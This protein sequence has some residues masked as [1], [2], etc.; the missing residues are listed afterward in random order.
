MDEDRIETEV[1][2][3]IKE[4]CREMDE[5]RNH[6]PKE[7]SEIPESQQLETFA[8]LIKFEQHKLAKSFKDPLELKLINDQIAKEAIQ[9]ITEVS[10]HSKFKGKFNVITVKSDDDVTPDTILF[11]N[12]TTRKRHIN[13]EGTLYKQFQESINKRIDISSNRDNE[14]QWVRITKK[15]SAIAVGIM[16][17]ILYKFRDAGNMLGYKKHIASR[18]SPDKPTGFEESTSIYQQQGDLMAISEKDLGAVTSSISSHLGNSE[19]NGFISLLSGAGDIW[20]IINQDNDDYLNPDIALLKKFGKEK[21][22]D[23]F[24]GFI[25]GLIKASFAIFLGHT[26]IAVFSAASMM[27]SLVAFG[28][29][30]MGL[31]ALYI[32]AKVVKKFMH[33]IGL[34]NDG[35]SILIRNASNFALFTRFNNLLR[36]LASMLVNKEQGS[37]MLLSDVYVDDFWSSVTESSDV[38]EIL[39]NTITSGNNTEIEKLYKLIGSM[40]DNYLISKLKTPEDVVKN[41]ENKNILSSSYETNIVYGYERDLVREYKTQF[42]ENIFQS[43][44]IKKQLNEEVMT[45]DILDILQTAYV[46]YQTYY[47]GHYPDQRE[48]VEPSMRF[49]FNEKFDTYD[50]DRN[51]GA[52][53]NL[54]NKLYEARKGKRNG[55]K[56]KPIASE[57]TRNEINNKYLVQ[58]DDEGRYV[59][60]T[61][62]DFMKEYILELKKDLATMEFTAFRHRY[63]TQDKKGFDTLKALIKNH[64]TLLDIKIPEVLEEKRNYSGFIGILL[65]QIIDNYIEIDALNMIN[66]NLLNETVKNSDDVTAEH[67]DNTSSILLSKMF[68][69]N[70]KILEALLIPTALEFPIKKY[71][72]KDINSKTFHAQSTVTSFLKNK[73]LKLAIK[74]TIY[75]TSY[76]LKLAFLEMMTKFQITPA[77]NIL[78]FSTSGGNTF[79]LA[80]KT[81]LE[82]HRGSDILGYSRIGDVRDINK[83]PGSLL[84]LTKE[85]AYL[86]SSSLITFFEN[87]KKF[88]FKTGLY[89]PLKY[90]KI[91]EANNC[92]DF[93]KVLYD[94]F[95]NETNAEYTFKNGS[96]YPH[97]VL[98]AHSIYAG[99]KLNKVDNETEVNLDMILTKQF[100]SLIGRALGVLKKDPI[101]ED[102]KVSFDIDEILEVSKDDVNHKKY[103]NYKYNDST[104]TY[105]AVCFE[106]DDKKYIIKKDYLDLVKLADWQ[107]AGEDGAEFREGIRMVNQEVLDNLG[108]EDIDE[109]ND[110]CLSHGSRY[111][112]I[113]ED[114][115]Q[116]KIRYQDYIP[117]EKTNIRVILNMEALT[118]IYSMES[119][120]DKKSVKLN[121][122]TSYEKG[123]F[124]GIYN[125]S[126][127]KA[128]IDLFINGLYHKR[129]YNI[130]SNNLLDI[131][132][133][134]N[135]CFHEVTIGFN[136]E[137]KK[138]MKIFKVNEFNSLHNWV[139]TNF[140]EISK[141]YNEKILSDEDRRVSVETCYDETYLCKAHKWTEG[142]NDPKLKWDKDYLDGILSIIISSYGSF[143]GALK[144][145]SQYGAFLYYLHHLPYNNGL[146]YLYP[147][148]K[149][150]L[151]DSY[152][153]S[154]Y[155]TKLSNELNQSGIENNLDKIDNLMSLKI[156]KKMNKTSSKYSFT[157]SDDFKFNYL[158]AFTHLVYNNNL[159]ADKVIVVKNTGNKVHSLNNIGF[160]LSCHDINSLAIYSDNETLI[161]NK[162][163]NI[164]GI[165]GNG[166]SLVAKNLLP[167]LN[168]ALPHLPLG[169][170]L[171]DQKYWFYYDPLRNKNILQCEGTV[172]EIEDSVANL[173]SNTLEKRM[174]FQDITDF[175]YKFSKIDN[176][177]NAVDK[178]NVVAVN[179]DAAIEE[180]LQISSHKLKAKIIA[181]LYCLS[182]IVK[183]RNLSKLPV[184][185]KDNM[186]K[187]LNSETW[188]FTSL[189]KYKVHFSDEDHTDRFKFKINNDFANQLLYL[190]LETFSRLMKIYITNKH[191]QLYGSGTKWEQLNE[192]QLFD[193]IKPEDIQMIRN[194]PLL[195]DANI[196]NNLLYSTTV[197]ISNNNN[198]LEADIY[199][200]PQRN[201]GA[202][203]TATISGLVNNLSAKAANASQESLLTSTDRV[204]SNFYSSIM[205]ELIQTEVIH[206]KVVGGQIKEQNKFSLDNK[207]KAAYELIF[208]KIDPNFISSFS[209]IQNRFYNNII[210]KTSNISVRNYIT[211]TVITGS[212]NDT[213]DHITT[214]VSS[215]ADRKLFFD[216]ILVSGD[217]DIYL[218]YIYNILR[219]NFQIGFN[220][221]DKTL[222]VVVDNKEH[223]SIIK[224]LL[225]VRLG[226]DTSDQTF[227]TTQKIK[228]LKSCT[229]QMNES[230]FCH[231]GC[232]HTNANAS[233]MFYNTLILG[234]FLST[235]VTLDPIASAYYDIDDYEDIS[236]F[237]QQGNHSVFYNRYNEFIQNNYSS[238]FGNNDKPGLFC[239]GHSMGG[240]YSSTFGYM[241]LF[242]AVK[243]R[244]DPQLIKELSQISAETKVHSFAPPRAFNLTTSVISEF[245]Y[246]DLFDLLRDDV[247]HG[248][249]VVNI[250]NKGDPIQK[251]PF[252]F[253][254]IGSVVLHDETIVNKPGKLLWDTEKA[255]Y[256]NKNLY[257]KEIEQ[258]IKKIKLTIDVSNTALIKAADDL[259][260]SV[261]DM[262]YYKLTKNIAEVSNNNFMTYVFKNPE[263]PGNS[264]GFEKRDSDFNCVKNHFNNLYVLCVEQKL[265]N[266]GLLTNNIARE[267]EEYNTT[268]EKLVKGIFENK[269]RPI[270]YVVENI[271]E[272]INLLDLSQTQ[273]GL[274][275]TLK[276]AVLNEKFI[277]E[278]QTTRDEI[279]NN[280]RTNY[281]INYNY[282]NF[283]SLAN[284]LSLYCHSGIIELVNL[285][286]TKNLSLH[287]DF[288]DLPANEYILYS[289]ENVDMNPGLLSSALYSRYAQDKFRE[290]PM[291]VASNYL[292]VI[293]SDIDIATENV[294][295]SSSNIKSREASNGKTLYYNDTSG[296]AVSNQ[297]LFSN[298]LIND[299]KN[300][301]TSNYSLETLFCNRCI[302]RNIV[303]KPKK[304]LLKG[305]VEKLSFS[306]LFCLETNKYYGYDQSW[307]GPTQHSTQKY[308]MYAYMANNYNDIL[309]TC[310]MTIKELAKN[311]KCNEGSVERI[312]E[313]RFDYTIESFK[314]PEKKI[315]LRATLSDIIKKVKHL[316]D[317]NRIELNGYL[318]DEL[319]SGYFSPNSGNNSPENMNNSVYKVKADLDE[320]DFGDVGERILKLGIKGPAYW[321]NIRLS[322]PGWGDFNKND[323]ISIT[324][325][326]SNYE[327]SPALKAAITYIING[328]NYYNNFNTEQGSNEDFKPIMKEQLF[329]L[330][331]LF[332]LDND[333]DCDA[334]EEAEAKKKAAEREMV[335]EIARTIDDSEADFATLLIGDGT[336]HN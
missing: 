19:Q 71:K 208:G 45:N 304:I 40:R 67:I 33:M 89:E 287:D 66:A 6:L 236:S 217:S 261:A 241:T 219:S 148:E 224:K 130:H 278:F 206:L 285:I 137:D 238:H 204:S 223:K 315:S 37:I 21:F 154:L 3:V 317:M 155:L 98:I 26:I 140:P 310:Q 252:I 295:L 10:N 131:L 336:S 16:S 209:K 123:I 266:L 101:N 182:L 200:K 11:Y 165:Y 251:V 28:A 169:L 324:V 39:Q 246:T 52:T 334:Y 273:I 283:D 103:K 335:L 288:W 9:I 242:Q 211:K 210:Q 332:I 301:L 227:T 189:E 23:G 43:V 120:L 83:E 77:K 53:K 205:D 180:P 73:V 36:W 311:V 104:G 58:A 177:I 13:K 307:A 151:Y 292:E 319:Q 270:E 99:D 156:F 119:E 1:N 79:G 222:E 27:A 51:Y 100:K 2:S 118:K 143:R 269:H 126:N 56:T 192:N 327:E 54:L 296:S 297:A 44:K 302:V 132:Y 271:V 282:E 201:M 212:E 74:S 157:I 188:R 272:L 322:R 303:C 294:S 196:V 183:L 262:R 279:L 122:L 128:E 109:L 277:S 12:S 22:V 184:K 32:L 281:Q 325:T 161:N 166:V 153:F 20:R 90:K 274:S 187:N 69:T 250:S 30:I 95:I 176:V 168:R 108:I 87:Y 330:L 105:N 218:D 115:S 199:V 64:V 78:N 72:E 147:N 88:M 321:S 231:T 267:E 312:S 232:T 48:Y 112:L 94:R 333:A 174:S 202:D 8:R 235:N 233:E 179:D 308:L 116:L 221:K 329:E 276:R 159:I 299:F 244:G 172:E 186:I 298:R 291:D 60:N 178:I 263:T 253:S 25:N 5:I 230:I 170:Q 258:Y 144:T 248:N 300:W 190:K 323:I 313:M 117:N 316:L 280:K 82:S 326:L 80:Y 164:D 256:S 245:L 57:R 121:E 15:W 239:T 18:L 306:E 309:N 124:D 141:L 228:I 17:V 216:G 24:V 318:I 149:G 110:T 97:Q 7:I 111:L 93:K 49:E 175:T 237:P 284:K 259:K 152:S 34:G 59:V 220:P 185:M 46:N 50:L 139:G 55:G 290:V 163:F 207:I 102:F 247:V 81:E 328:L 113:I 254:H 197:D 173:T 138:H 249:I 92:P 181:H 107:E 293:T 38:L 86:D 214:D 289:N 84:D 76:L 146:H 106:D 134:K 85:I 14:A 265:I 127:F 225:N 203:L 286:R 194:Y 195:N 171:M 331:N 213:Y 215:S 193:L 198:M 305:D 257:D 68:K 125:S 133:N 268:R 47:I 136:Q 264:M 243:Y 255:L 41:S 226:G 42:L 63:E 135:N 96:I 150:L 320:D 234:K 260:V 229:K 191:S 145:T 114:E 167:S 91:I 31:I 75:N 61:S 65:G 29:G 314:E 158:L 142:N 62:N 160:M 35:F 4:F 129:L 70:K 162:D 240:G 275:M